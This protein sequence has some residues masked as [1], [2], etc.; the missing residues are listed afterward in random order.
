MYGL[1]RLQNPDRR[2]K[3]Y[4]VHTSLISSNLSGFTYSSIP[5]NSTLPHKAAGNRTVLHLS[6]SLHFLLLSSA[7]IAP[8]CVCKRAYQDI[9]LGLTGLTAF[10]FLSYWYNGIQLPLIEPHWCVKCQINHLLESGV[11]CPRQ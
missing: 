1:V 5:L 3:E 11:T 9:L 7:N 4:S 8:R 6:L 10:R 2:M